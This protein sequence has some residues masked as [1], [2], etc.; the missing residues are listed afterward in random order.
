MSDLRLV[1]VDW[2]TA[3]LFCR[4]WHRH[5]PKPPP[6]H[7]FRTGVANEEDVLVGVAIVG[8]P[9]AAAFQDGLTVEVNRTVTDGYKN[10]NSMLYAAVARAAF[11]LGYRRIVT[12]TEEGGSG[13]SLRAADYRVVARRPPRKGWDSPSRP[14]APGRDFVPRT[15]WEKRTVGAPSIPRS[16]GMSEPENRQ[17][18]ILTAC[19]T[20]HEAMKRFC[21]IC[22]YGEQYDHHQMRN[23]KGYHPFMPQEQSDE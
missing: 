11:A 10:A 23:A 13:A 21:R 2:Q 12:Y 3:R 7:I 20:L 22:G 16:R 17:D 4:S 19:E 14:R 5:H 18:I 15:L 8:R 6:G 9:V 1:P